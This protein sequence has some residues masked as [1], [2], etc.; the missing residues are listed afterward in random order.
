MIKSLI[1][2]LLVVYLI[3]GLLW[4]F[5]P[6]V[7]DYEP[8]GKIKTRVKEIFLYPFY[9]PHNDWLIKMREES[10]GKSPMLKAI[11]FV[12]RDTHV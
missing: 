11:K 3:P 2:V 8:N 4:Y 10:D 1:V 7:S 6:G 12:I 5:D 9:W